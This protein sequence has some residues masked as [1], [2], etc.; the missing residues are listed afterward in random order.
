MIC[1]RETVSLPQTELSSPLLA[2]KLCLVHILSES[3]T[4]AF[5][6]LLLKELLLRRWLRVGGKD[7]G[8]TRIVDY[9]ARVYV[10]STYNI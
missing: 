9:D 7:C 6:V 2:F 8:L 10:C 1:V 4:V 3:L 5:A